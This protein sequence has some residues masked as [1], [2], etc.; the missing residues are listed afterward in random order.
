MFWLNS[1]EECQ[2]SLHVCNLICAV[3]CF[4]EKLCFRRKKLWKN[5][6]RPALQVFLDCR[7][8]LSPHVVRHSEGWV[9]IYNVKELKME[10]I[11]APTQTYQIQ[12]SF[13]IPSKQPPNTCKAG[14]AI[15]F[16]H[17]N[18][19]SWNTQAVTQPPPSKTRNNLV[20]FLKMSGWPGHTR[21]HWIFYLKREGGGGGK[22]KGG[23]MG[24]QRGEGGEGDNKFS[25][26]KQL[27][28]NRHPSNQNYLF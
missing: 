21:P 23:W 2:F 6:G 5:V 1:R 9:K 28:F 16:S 25:G 10:M 8:L 24:G 3:G 22:N 27:I 20:L 13:W 11:C 17:Q 12:N 4:R 18:M 26:L 15:S 14:W 19:F 7:F